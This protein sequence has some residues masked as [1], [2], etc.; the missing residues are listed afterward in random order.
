[1]LRTPALSFLRLA[2]ALGALACAETARAAP[3][4]VETPALAPRARGPYVGLFATSFV[5]DGLRFNNPY[6]LATPLGSDAESVARTAAYADVGAAATLGDPRGLQHGLA[7]RTSI[8]LEG[9][10]Q[11]VF[12]PSYLL[13]RRWRAFA[14][15]GRLGVPILVTPTS[16]AGLEIAGGGVWFVRSGIGVAAELV[17]DLVYGAGTREV[18]RPAYPILSAQLGL[19]L[20]YEVLP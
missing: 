12:T 2:C 10:A 13:Y 15:Y 14:A 20:A 17:G 8:A 19:I 7:L 3:E 9:I 1:V 11:V 5:G 6:R 16:N 4:D 18:A